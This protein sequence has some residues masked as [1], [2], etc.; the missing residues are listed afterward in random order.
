MISGLV[1]FIP[2]GVDIVCCVRSG[3]NFFVLHMDTQ[4]SQYH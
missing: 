1:F 3:S 2:F 4:F